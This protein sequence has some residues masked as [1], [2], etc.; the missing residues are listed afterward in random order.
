M[1]DLSKTPSACRQRTEMPLVSPEKKREEVKSQIGPGCKARWY[2]S[3]GFTDVF[4]D[5]G[6]TPVVRHQVARWDD[7]TETV[8]I[9]EQLQ[10]GMHGSHPVHWGKAEL[11][12]GGDVASHLILLIRGCLSALRSTA[13]ARETGEWMEAEEMREHTW[14]S[15]LANAS[16]SSLVLL[17]SS[18]ESIHS[19]SHWKDDS[20]ASSSW[21]FSKTSS[22]VMS[23]PV[24]AQPRAQVRLTVPLG[25]G[26]ELP[27]AASEVNAGTET[28]AVG[29][30]SLPLAA[31]VDAVACLLGGGIST[32]PSSVSSSSSLVAEERCRFAT[33][34]RRCCSDSLVLLPL[35]ADTDVVVC[36]L[37]GGTSTTSS[38]ASF[39][40]A[41]S[42]F[43]AAEGR[44]RFARRSRRS[45]SMALRSRAPNWN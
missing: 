37:G 26:R 34:S 45:C 24:R 15:S 16:S 19:S 17:M 7:D 9:L 1:G 29:F 21:S 27:G 33:R 38:S 28:D 11:D 40:S 42:S 36:L 23:S 43:L 39:G 44:C 14:A 32:T 8:R 10:F 41:S 3:K 4:H 20:R 35:T 5:P 6:L 2:Q 13:V 25:Y 22:M 18:L 30:D 12:V 31:D